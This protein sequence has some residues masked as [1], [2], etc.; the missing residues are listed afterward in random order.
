MDIVESLM[1]LAAEMQPQLVLRFLRS[2][3]VEKKEYNN[4]H[5]ELQRFVATVRENE[6]ITATVTRT[7]DED[8]MTLE[9]GF[10]EHEAREAIV[11][12]ARKQAKKLAKKAGIELKVE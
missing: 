11:E 12:A 6:G 9:M 4:V 10:S 2:D 8:A 7:D 5:F 1:R 3:D